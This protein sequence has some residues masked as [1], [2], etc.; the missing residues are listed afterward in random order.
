MSRRRPNIPQRKRVFL[1]CEGESEAS[2]G[3][4]LGWLADEPPP[5]DVH[6]EPRV[7]QPGA[8]DPLELVRRAIDLIGRIERC[9]TR[10]AAAS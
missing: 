10:S 3:A 6:I 7:L 5:L 9:R 8:G 2:Y 1:G 4:L